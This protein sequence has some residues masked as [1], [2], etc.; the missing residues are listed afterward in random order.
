MDCKRALTESDGDIE[1]AIDLLRKKGQKVAA[2]RAGRTA[3]QGLIVTCISGDGRAG[4][5]CEVNCETDF[6]ARNSEFAAFA[7]GVGAIVANHAPP[8]VDALLAL[9]YAGGR[10]VGE[11][12]TDLTGKI[13]EKMG[14]GRF[15]LLQSETGQVVDYVHPGARLAVLVA[16]SGSD[17]LQQIGTDIAMQVAAMNP[18]AAFRAEVPADVQ[19][20]ELDIARAAA[21]NEGK[22]EHIVD[23]IAKGKLERYFKDHVLFEQP[24]VKD[25][26]V[27]VQDVLKQAGAELQAFVRYQLGG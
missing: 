14:I 18:V 13:G 12:L 5:I 11:A 19:E 2:K 3:S 21:L 10:T 17:S 6:V 22:P 20:K 15:Q 4:A 1:A 27:R 26:S 25:A 16:L 9:D 8:D 23:R 7:E 24:F